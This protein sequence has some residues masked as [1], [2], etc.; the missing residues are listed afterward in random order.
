MVKQKWDE[1]KRD[2]AAEE[3]AFMQQQPKGQAMTEPKPA[4]PQDGERKAFEKW[5]DLDDAGRGYGRG[6]RELAWMG[7]QARASQPQQADRAL[8]RELR[9][10]L[11]DSCS[12]RSTEMPIEVFD[13][14]AMA[15]AAEHGG[16]KL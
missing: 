14:L 12:G 5:W 6:S 13:V 8:L 4:A 2:A 1:D 10:R 9:Q 7:W 3:V 16:T 15:P 11:L